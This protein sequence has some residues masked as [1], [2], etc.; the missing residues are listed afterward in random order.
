MPD[1]VRPNVMLSS[2]MSDHAAFEAAKCLML[3]VLLQAGPI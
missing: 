3:H 1:V 2:E